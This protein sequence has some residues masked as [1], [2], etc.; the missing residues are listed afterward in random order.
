MD[1]DA[2]AAPCAPEGA[3]EA[4]ATCAIID[5]FI[6]RRH[7]ADLNTTIRMLEQQKD[8][9]LEQVNALI[10]AIA[11]LKGTDRGARLP[12]PA[13]E[14]RVPASAR[15]AARPKRKRH[16]V[17]S[18]EHKQKLLEGQ[19]RSRERRQG[20]PANGAAPAAAAEWSASSAP[21]LVKPEQPD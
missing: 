3:A 16:F 19:R 2:T 18:E 6:G 1:V 21:R 10:R 14:P 13:A 9:L 17:L 5:T 7:M 8:E 12:P 20:A 15:A 4:R 11:A